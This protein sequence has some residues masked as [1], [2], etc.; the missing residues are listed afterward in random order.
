MRQIETALYHQAHI[1]LD[2][3]TTLSLDQRKLLAEHF[4]VLPFTLK[5]TH[6]DDETTKFLFETTDGK[7]IETVLLY[8]YHHDKT[9]GERKLNRVTLCISSQV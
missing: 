1:H 3:I 8:H 2:E 5:S 9:T 7:V 4:C 6:S